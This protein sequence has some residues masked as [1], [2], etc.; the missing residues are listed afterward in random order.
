M[1]MDDGTGAM[2]TDQDED[3]AGALGQST[4]L[5]KKVDNALK[6]LVRNATEEFGFAPRDTYDCIFSPGEIE[7]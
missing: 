1:E 3:M 6:I 5:E 4:A 7:R 2:T